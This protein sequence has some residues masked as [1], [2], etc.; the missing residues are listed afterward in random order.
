MRKSI[1]VVCAVLAVAA[2]T[3]VVSAQGQPGRHL[4]WT[5]IPESSVERP[6][7]VGLE[8]HTNHQIQVR[9]DATGLAP[10]GVEPTD[11][12]T[13]YTGAS[14]APGGSRV[15]VIVDAFHYPTALSDFNTFSRQFGLP[16]ESSSTATSQANQVFQVVYASGQQPAADCGWAQEAAL[17]IEWAHAMAPGAKIVLVE[18]TSNSFADLFK[19]VDVATSI[20]AATG[21]Q[22]SMSWGGSEFR[23]ETG[24][25]SHFSTNANVVYFAS[26]GDS[27]GKTMYP[28]VSP[29]V[30]AA[31]GTTL[32]YNA[33]GAIVGEKG[34]SGSGGGQ[35]RY[36]AIPG[37]QVNLGVKMP[38]G[39]KRRG[40]PDISFDA[41][42][43]TGVSVFD[44]TPCGGSSGWMV[45]GGT[46]VS[47]PC[48]A[49][50]AS[51][52]GP[53]AL[54]SVAELQTIYAT[55][56]ANKTYYY[57]VTTGSAGRNKAGVGWDYVT[58]IGTLRS[59]FGM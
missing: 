6:G 44:S 18:A 37:Y 15:I 2:A 48:L 21:G 42:P 28:S 50:L 3:L 53:P 43:S 4:G 55:S 46:S 5:V 7:R 47:S 8:A 33:A 59:L 12:W 14:V 10:A 39:I 1:A 13:L 36:E 49:A 16:V 26:S 40:V 17:D 57:D 58:G 25:D 24:Y 23:G 22:V 45:F 27:G 56:V 31:G 30:V 20:A 38:A 41:D 34:W 9:P 52:G 32:L 54:D 19:A 51:A 11:L 29:N 35:S